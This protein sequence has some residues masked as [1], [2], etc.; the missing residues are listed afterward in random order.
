M[1]T[2]AGANFPAPS[3]ARAAA[4]RVVAAVLIDGRSLATAL[5]REL[6]RLHAAPSRAATQD[7]AYN[8]LRFTHRMRFL[9]PRLL[10]RPLKRRDGEVEALLLVG[11]TQLLELGTPAHAA[12]ASTVEACGLIDRDWAR[13]LC[14]AVL[15]RA[16][17]D[18]DALTRAIDLDAEARHAHPAWF[19]EAVQAAW[20]EAAT[21]ILAAGNRPPPM[22]LRVNRRA[23]SREEAAARLERAGLRTSPCRWAADGLRLAAAADTAALPGFADGGISVQ[24]EAAQLAADLLDLAPGLRV[25]DACAAPGGKTAH[26][27][28]REPQLAE[29]VA[30]EQDAQRA[31]LIDDTLRRLRLSARLVTADATE[32]AGWWDGRPFD[33]VLLDAPC[34]GSGV[35]RR[36]PDIKHLRRAEDIARLAARQARLLDALWPLLAPGGRL[37]YVTCSVLPQEGDDVIVGFLARQPAARAL[38]ITTGWGQA[39]AHGRQILPGS[40]DDTDGFFHACLTHI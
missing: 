38:P 30:V 14:N 17:R 39:T 36:H 18:R 37:V 22:T 27:A 28:E 4:A 15:R 3:I 35:I 29:L 24:D 2:A 16:D 21:A 20:G 13:G 25:L 23:G 34:S 6:S 10:E 9:L 33:R 8:T 26:I 31:R 5:P 1:N 12:V 7:L 32:V 40:P 11:L 19:I